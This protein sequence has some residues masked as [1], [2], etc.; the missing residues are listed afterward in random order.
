M[1]SRCNHKGSIKLIGKSIGVQNNN[2]TGSA[3]WNGFATIEKHSWWREKAEAVSVDM[4]MDS[5]IE[6]KVELCVPG[7]KVAA[8]GLK[9]NV[10]VNGKLVGKAKCVKMLTRE[11][12]TPFESKIHDRIPL[13]VIKGDIY[14]FSEKD[15][16][17]SPVQ[18]E[19]F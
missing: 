5:F 10:M 12:R 4:L 15:V 7:G 9:R 3:V 16:I 8:L 2:R 6:G 19:L 14:I 17:S 13:V 1:C 18:K 11:A